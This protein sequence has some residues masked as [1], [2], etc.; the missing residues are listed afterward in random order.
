MHYCCQLYSTPSRSQ[1]SCG[2]KKPK[3]VK[4]NIFNRNRYDFLEPSYPAADRIKEGSGSERERLWQTGFHLSATVL[5]PQPGQSKGAYNVAV[6]FDRCR[7]TSCSCTCGAGAKWCAHVV[8]LCLFRIHNVS[9]ILS[10]GVD[11][12]STLI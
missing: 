4:V 7:I 9:A 5:S 8:A 6:M 11:R 3:L 1:S 12:H 2:E 10:V